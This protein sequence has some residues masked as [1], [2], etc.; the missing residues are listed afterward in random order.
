MILVFPG[1]VPK[2]MLCFGRVNGMK[3]I[4]QYAPTALGVSTRKVEVANEKWLFFPGR[5]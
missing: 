5:L 1:Y 4:N 2:A 3:E